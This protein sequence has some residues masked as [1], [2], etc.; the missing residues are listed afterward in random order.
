MLWHLCSKIKILGD[1]RNK[2]VGDNSFNVQLLALTTCAA[3]QNDTVVKTGLCVILGKNA[4]DAKI[5][6]TTN[7]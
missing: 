7:M 2:R 3:F 1:K 4:T 6:S 5:I